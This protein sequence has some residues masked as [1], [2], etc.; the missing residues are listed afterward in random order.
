MFVSYPLFVSISLFPRWFGRVY[1]L[2]I[3]ISGHHY[4]SVCR[5]TKLPVSAD[6][7][8]D[9]LVRSLVSVPAYRTTTILDRAYVLITI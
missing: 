9:Y 1:V 5:T 2:P 3:K 4:C 7:P 6:V 8:T